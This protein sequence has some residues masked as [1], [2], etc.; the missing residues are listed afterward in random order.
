MPDYFKGLMYGEN[1]QY[2][3]MITTDASLCYDIVPQFLMD[4]REVF[5]PHGDADKSVEWLDT[6]KVDWSVVMDGGDLDEK[7][8]PLSWLAVKTVEEGEEWY[9]KHTKMPDDMIRYVARYYWGDGLVDKTNKTT[10]KGRKKKA[11]RGEAVDKFECHKG[12][13]QVKFD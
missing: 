13:F 2:A 10:K 11:Q 5:E 12:H 6:D 4:V 9:S 8:I 7:G 1:N 3:T